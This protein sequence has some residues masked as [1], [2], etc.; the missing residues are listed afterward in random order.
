MFP[1]L[2][3]ERGRD[4]KREDVCERERESTTKMEGR[5]RFKIK[6]NW[7]VRLPRLCL[8]PEEIHSGLG[9]FAWMSWTLLPP[10][11]SEQ[12]LLG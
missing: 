4:K 10:S 3:G 1:V 5:K 11:I 8:L 7:T 6:T 2:V 12:M 9:P